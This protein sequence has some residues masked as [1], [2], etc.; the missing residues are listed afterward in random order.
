MIRLRD[1]AVVCRPCNAERGAAR[2][3]RAHE[4]EQWERDLDQLAHELDMEDD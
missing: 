3:E 2:G 4:H 1:V